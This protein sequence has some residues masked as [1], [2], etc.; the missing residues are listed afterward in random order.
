M[1]VAARRNV[2][3][4]QSVY[5]LLF[6]FEAWTV[7]SWKAIDLIVNS[8]LSTIPVH[9]TPPEETLQTTGAVIAETIME[10]HDT[11]RAR[12]GVA[13]FSN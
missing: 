11:E 9:G 10:I 7:A 3:A 4:W 8:G 13:A 5:Q 1:L 12:G 6:H 2:A